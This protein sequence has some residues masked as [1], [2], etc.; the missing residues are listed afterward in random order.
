MNIDFEFLVNRYNK[1]KGLCVYYN[2]PLQFGNYVDKIWM[3]SLEKKMFVKNIQ[4]I[5]SV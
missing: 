4:K 5:M 2:I 3:I 1:Q